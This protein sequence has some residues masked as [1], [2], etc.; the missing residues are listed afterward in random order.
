[1]NNVKRFSFQQTLQSRQG[2]IQFP[3]LIQ[4]TCR[5]FRPQLVRLADYEQAK[6]GF[7]KVRLGF[8]ILVLQHECRRL[9]HACTDN[10]GAMLSAITDFHQDRFKPGKA[11]KPDEYLLHNIES[12]P[13][14]IQSDSATPPF[15]SGSKATTYLTHYAIFKC[16]PEP[17]LI[18]T[19]AGNN[20]GLPFQGAMHRAFIGNF[21]Q[22]LAHIVA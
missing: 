9:D 12:C 8:N 22:P 3:P 4:L 18:T 17:L 6:V 21:N 20:N 15:N 10:I 11:I 1:M 16:E 2:P 19:I 7:T 5:T 14:Q 13:G